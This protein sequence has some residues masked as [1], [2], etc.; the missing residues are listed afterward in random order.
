MDRVNCDGEESE[1]VIFPA[2]RACIPSD[3]AQVSVRSSCHQGVWRLE[4]TLAV[5]VKVSFTRHAVPS[6]TA[7]CRANRRAGPDLATEPP[8]PPAASP[9]TLRPLRPGSG[10]PGTAASDREP[11][12]DTDPAPGFRR[13][14]ESSRRAAVPPPRS[15]PV[16]RRLRRGCCGPGRRASGRVPGVLE[17]ARW[18]S[19]GRPRP[20]RRPDGP[21]RR[22]GW[23]AG[24]RCASGRGRRAGS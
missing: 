4:R 15:F 7:R 23:F 5:T 19:V 2:P 22:R 9:R 21:L 12:G 8:R 16:T 1:K 13:A 10:P 11:F 17:S 14:G 18:L 20:R 3:P 24:R 6:P